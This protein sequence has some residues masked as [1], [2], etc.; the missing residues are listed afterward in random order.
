MLAH[1]VAQEPGRQVD[2]D[3]VAVRSG[4]AHLPQPCAVFNVADLLLEAPADAVPL[5]HQSV[6]VPAS[7]C[8][9][10]DISRS[11]NWLSYVIAPCPHLAALAA[12]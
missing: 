8:T 4:Q 3:L 10:A 9:T 2:G 1:P 7:P 12:A 11:I 6:C 5:G